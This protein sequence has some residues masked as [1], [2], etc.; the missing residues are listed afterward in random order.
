[1]YSRSDLHKPAFG[2]DNVPAAGYQRFG[3]ISSPI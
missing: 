2:A 3:H 1:L